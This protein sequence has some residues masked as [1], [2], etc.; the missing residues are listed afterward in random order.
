MPLSVPF[1]PPRNGFSSFVRTN[2]LRQAL[3]I[4]AFLIIQILVEHLHDAGR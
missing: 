2:P 3:W 4:G 1:E